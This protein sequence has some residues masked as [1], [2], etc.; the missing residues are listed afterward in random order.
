METRTESLHD[1]INNFKNSIVLKQKIYLVR[2]NFRDK[3]SHI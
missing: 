2:F 3:T 1:Y